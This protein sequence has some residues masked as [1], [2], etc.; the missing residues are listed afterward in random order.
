MNLL[1]ELNYKCWT[2][3]NNEFV[4]QIQRLEKAKVYQSEIKSRLSTDKKIEFD[5]I[6]FNLNRNHQYLINQLETLRDK[7]S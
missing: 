5:V 6:C 2:I 1:D 7:H 3:Y 4:T